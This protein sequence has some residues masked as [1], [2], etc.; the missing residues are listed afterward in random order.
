MDLA[1][2]NRMN[3]QLEEGWLFS[4]SLAPG[5][6]IQ[7]VEVRKDSG[8]SGIGFPLDLC[9]ILEFQTYKTLLTFNL[10]Y[11]CLFALLLSLGHHILY[12]SANT[13]IVCLCLCINTNIGQ[14]NSEHLIT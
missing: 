10:L 4:I 8:W 9:A 3:Q 13:I 14:Q 7:A 6:T 12:V 11:I 2:P 1:A 5:L